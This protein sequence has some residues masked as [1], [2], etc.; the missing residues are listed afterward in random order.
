MWCMQLGQ[1]FRPSFCV[2]TYR[3][4]S[5]VL[6]VATRAT[7]TLKKLLKVQR[8]KRYGLETIEFR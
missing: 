6:L 3:H 7:T 2:D 5:E 1:V 4:T 8:L